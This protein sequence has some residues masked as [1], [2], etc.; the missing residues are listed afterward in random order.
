MLRLLIDQDFNQRIL[1]GLRQRMSELNAVTAY[2]VG[3]SAASDK[4]LLSWAAKAGRAL[5]THDRRT[6]P[7]HAANII[8]RGEETAGLIVVPRRLPIIEAINDL[9]IIAACSSAEEWNNSIRFLPL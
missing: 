2:D 1:R 4:E 8:K 7:D 5:V 9:E 6:M 3:L